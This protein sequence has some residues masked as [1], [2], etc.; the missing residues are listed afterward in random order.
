[1]DHTTSTMRAQRARETGDRT[2]LDDLRRRF[3]TFRRTRPFWGCVIL[4]LG[5]YFIIS[6]VLTSVTAMVSLGPA[7]VNGWVIGGV[8]LGAAAISLVLPSQRF[9]AGIVAMI[10]SVASLVMT[11]LGGYV[12]GMVFGIIGSGLIF[13]WAPDPEDGQGRHRSRAEARERRRALRRGAATGE[14]IEQGD[15]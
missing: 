5:A 6:P 9:F 12:L 15:A 1:M 14:A 3:R 2:G 11:N 4:T 7:A 8:M 13:A 10:V